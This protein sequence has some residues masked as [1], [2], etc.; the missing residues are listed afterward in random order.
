[1][2]LLYKCCERKS[3]K[4]MNLVLKLKKAN[5]KTALVD[6]DNNFLAEIKY[7][8]GT[9]L[10][11]TISS[12]NKQINNSTVHCENKDC[13]YCSIKNK[14]TL[15][16]VKKNEILSINQYGQCLSYSDDENDLA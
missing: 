13:I 10:T 11:D 12:I 2:N 8:Q 14:C 5:N 9:L 16:S 4:I 1:M 6:E 7:E 15:A 3:F